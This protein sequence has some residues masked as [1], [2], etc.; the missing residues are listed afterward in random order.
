GDRG[1]TRPRTRA[2]R[3]RGRR[4]GRLPR[5]ADRLLR[6]RPLELQR[7]DQRLRLDLLHPARRAPRA[8]RDRARAVAVVAGPHG[9]RDDRLPPDRAARDRL[10]LVLRRGG[11]DLRRR[12]PGV[13]VVIWFGLFGGAAAWAAMLVAGVALSQAR[14]DAAGIDVGLHPATLAVT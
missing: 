5:D 12:D 8:R 7:H 14:C 11:G 1:R 6:A 9:A 13:A 10:L 2:G 4:P 3:A